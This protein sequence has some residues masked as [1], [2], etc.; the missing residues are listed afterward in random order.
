MA[1]SS[2]RLKGGAILPILRKFLSYFPSQHYLCISFQCLLFPPT[3]HWIGYRLCRSAKYNSRSRWISP[4]KKHLYTHLQHFANL[5]QK[6]KCFLYISSLHTARARSRESHQHSSEHKW[7]I[8]QPKGEPNRS[9]THSASTAEEFLATSPSAT[10]SSSSATNTKLARAEGLQLAS[11]CHKP[12]PWLENH[13]PVQWDSRILRTN[14]QLLATSFHTAQPFGKIPEQCL[15][16]NWLKPPQTLYLAG[17][18][19]TP[20]FK[21]LQVLLALHSSYFK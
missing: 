7:L 2:L 10:P 6:D 17:I 21:K 3:I 1:G 12:G 5:W 15:F 13:L 20:A 4:A 18:L 14:A 9:F 11:F 16:S 19:F 8:T